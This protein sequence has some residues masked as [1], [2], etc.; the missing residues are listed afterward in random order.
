M[1]HV[2]LLLFVLFVPIA[3][4]ENTFLSLVSLLA[5]PQIK[6]NKQILMPIY[7]GIILVYMSLN[8]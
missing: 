1:G 8:L 2:F 6:E 3:T 7:A 5:I 4:W